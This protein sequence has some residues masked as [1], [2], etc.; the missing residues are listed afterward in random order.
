MTISMY[1]EVVDYILI[2]PRCGVDNLHHGDVLHYHR[3]EDAPTVTKTRVS[4]GAIT[5][6]R[7]EP[8]DRSHNPSARRGG[9]RIL[10]ECENCGDGLE[11]TIAQHKGLTC[12]GWEWQ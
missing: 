9:L 2:C 4:G 8:S 7:D 6:H 5:E 10:F 1:V 12:V 11:L 3:R